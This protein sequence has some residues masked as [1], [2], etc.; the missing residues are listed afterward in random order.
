MLN[1][2]IGYTLEDAVSAL[3]NLGFTVSSKEVRS[4]KGIDAPDTRIVIRQRLIDEN[5]V[6]LCFSCV[7]KR[8]SACD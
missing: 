8:P 1:C 4:K 5:L 2:Y 7:K 6:E 3:L